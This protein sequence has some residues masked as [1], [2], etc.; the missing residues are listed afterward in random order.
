MTKPY[1]E[2]LSLFIAQLFYSTTYLDYAC[3]QSYKA[4]Q[5]VA[6]TEAEF[7]V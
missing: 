1:C 2:T 5:L 7:Y 3:A 6:D 4:F